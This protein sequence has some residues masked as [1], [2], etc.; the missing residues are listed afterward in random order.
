MFAPRRPPAPAA[1][2]RVTEG[3][4][5]IVALRIV[6]PLLIFR[7]PLAGGIAAIIVD[8]LD[9]VLVDAMGLGGF[10]G[11]YHQFDKLLDIYYLTIELIVALRWDNPYARNPAIALFAYRA[12][13]V[14]LFEITKQRIM[15]FAFPNLFENWWIF[16]VAA[17]R[18]WPRLYP[19]SVQAVAVALVVLLVPKVAQEYV[20][21]YSE[22][23]PW[24]WI[25]HNVLHTQ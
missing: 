6:V 1:R 2:P 10:Q 7:Q 16:C 8:T 3:A 23:Q 25:K 9:V 5:I 11:N 17:S 18:Y 19:R 22:A 20:L 21:H 12:C 15:L 14:L 24:D 4:T 13:G